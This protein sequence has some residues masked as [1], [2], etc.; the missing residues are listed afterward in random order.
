MALAE[1]R[2]ARPL[3]P[4]PQV[5]SEGHTDAD[6]PW[7]RRTLSCTQKCTHGPQAH[8]PTFTHSALYTSP[9]HTHTHKYSTTQRE[10]VPPEQGRGSRT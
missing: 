5:L 3:C 1:D 2:E 9:K 8:R 7:A 10:S 6:N 4:H